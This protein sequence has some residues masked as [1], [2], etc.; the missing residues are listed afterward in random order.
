[1]KSFLLSFKG[2]MSGNAPDYQ[3]FHK[4]YELLNTCSVFPIPSRLHMSGLLAPLALA[5]TNIQI[6]PRMVVGI[7]KAEAGAFPYLTPAWST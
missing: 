6:N 4:P 1:M 3:R 5:P 7:P 2:G